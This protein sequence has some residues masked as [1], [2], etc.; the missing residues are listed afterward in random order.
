[1]KVRKLLFAMIALASMVS[2]A[3][4]RI[5][6]DHKGNTLSAKFL[7]F[8][9]DK[10]FMICE[11]QKTG[12]I[13]AI[14]PQLLSKEDK[15]YVESLM[16]SSIGEI[17]VKYGGSWTMKKVVE[18]LKEKNKAQRREKGYV[19][20]AGRIIKAKSPQKD[21]RCFYVRVFQKLGE[22]SGLCQLGDFQ[23]SRSSI[24]PRD[25]YYKLS[26]DSRIFYCIG[27]PDGSC[28]EDS[29]FQV[30]DLYWAGTYK[31]N[32]RDGH[33]KVVDIL[34]PEYMLAVHLVRV[35]KSLYDNNDPR[36]A[37]FSKTSSSIS[38]NNEDSSNH[39]NND[40][41]TLM[42]FGSGFIISKDGY[43]VT[44]YHVIKEGRMFK[45][46]LG[47][48]IYLAEFVKHDAETDLAVLKI[49]GSFEPLKMAANRI[50][51][52]GREIFTIGFPQP[53]YQGFAPKITKGI[54]SAG[55]GFKGDI[56]RYQID[57]AIQ[58]GNS[59]GPVADANG[60]LVGVVV[61]S[62]VAGKS[63]NVNYA[64][65]K[66]YL[67]AFLDSIPQCANSIEIANGD[68][69]IEFEDAV[70]KVQKSCVQILVYK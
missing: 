68:S 35:D 27:I 12:K 44:N 5:W 43:L 7:G 33:F 56:R 20:E 70:A 24:D 10:K 38:S 53:R 62:L 2:V 18:K 39:M 14:V 34:S 28:Y 51:R 29:E 49:S 3:D 46:C 66:S 36:F 37:R 23:R 31:Y 45:A 11:N 57:A 9:E 4:Y 17:Y 15:T 50:E 21:G 67:L 58:P 60:N 13:M 54:I 25:G 52:P 6:K 61:S 55:E 41:P 47:S 22:N 59:G 16:K 32:T 8:S 40:R 19:L 48:D 69:K 1:M 65:K 64:V 63:Q 26:I 30:K 42:G